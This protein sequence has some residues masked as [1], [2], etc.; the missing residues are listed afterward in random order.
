MS[1]T[2]NET[3]STGIMA[4]ALL[5]LGMGFGAGMRTQRI[6]TSSLTKYKTT[7]H[8]PQHLIETRRPLIGICVRVPDG[9]NFRMIHV[10]FNIPIV[11]WVYVH[12][13]SIEMRLNSYSSNS[14]SSKRVKD[15]LN[16]RLAGVD[17][18][19]SQAFSMPAQPYS[20]ES[21]R[22]LEQLIL[23]RPVVAIP[24]RRD[25]YHRL[26]A[27]VYLYPHRSNYNHDSTSSNKSNSGL[28]ER[29]LNFISG[30]KNVSML[31]VR[32]GCAHVYRSAGAEYETELIREQLEREESQAR[33]KCVGLWSQPL[34]SHPSEHKSKH[35]K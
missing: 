8:I 10:P 22:Y 16:I 20:Q 7:Q 26:V 1:K 19:E 31:M 17:A 21:R 30:N 32:A 3:S 4:G 28:M 15:T 34:T 23:N 29:Y 13:K 18:P 5:L 25:Q 11:T 27:M 24:L 33:S 14:N 9:D 35:L 6:I 12:L 2:P